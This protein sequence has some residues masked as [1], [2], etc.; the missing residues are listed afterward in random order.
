MNLPQNTGIARTPSASPKAVD[1]LCNVLQLQ[2]H[3]SQVFQLL[4]L[5]KQRA[6][7]T[8]L[9]L[10]NVCSM[11][12]R[13]RAIFKADSVSL[14]PSPWAEGVLTA[15]QLILGRWVKF[16]ALDWIGAGK[17]IN[18]LI[19]R[20]GS[21]NS[22]IFVDLKHHYPVVA[23]CHVTAAGAVPGRSHSR[24]REQEKLYAILYH[25]DLLTP[26]NICI[27]QYPVS[28]DPSTALCNA[29]TQWHTRRICLMG[30]NWWV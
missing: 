28:A 22:L 13:G 27:N 7:Y 15:V 16:P 29:Q 26:I 20:A 21:N 6:F 9:T 24:H 8:S 4:F 11:E 25:D 5:W 3:G 18:I 1:L 12:R 23:S 19:L 30:S 10:A 2:I 14:L 17:S